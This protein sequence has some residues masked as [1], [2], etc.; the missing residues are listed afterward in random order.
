MIKVTYLKHCTFNID[1]KKF[2]VD[3]ALVLDDNPQHRPSVVKCNPELA[4]IDEPIFYDS[5]EDLRYDS[6][7]RLAR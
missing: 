3:Y 1:N 6:H 5:L 7:Q 4:G 2:E